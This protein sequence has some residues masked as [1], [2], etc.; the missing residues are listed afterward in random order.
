MLLLFPIY[1]QISRK[2]EKHVIATPMIPCDA[3]E[4]EKEKGYMLNDPC[5][6]STLV[7]RNEV[8]KVE[9]YRRYRKW[10]LVTASVDQAVDDCG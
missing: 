4:G 2:K 10:D 8:K 5:A 7:E 1:S 9:I 6:W 3:N